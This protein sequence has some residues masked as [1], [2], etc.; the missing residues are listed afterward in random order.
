MAALAIAGSVR[1]AM[2]MNSSE[3]GICDEDLAGGGAHMII[4]F[5]SCTCNQELRR[6]SR[7]ELVVLPRI[8]AGLTLAS[9]LGTF[10]WI[11]GMAQ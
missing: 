4:I 3:K 10:L 5:H 2:P 8:M 1:S 9:G 6:P 11:L 7:F